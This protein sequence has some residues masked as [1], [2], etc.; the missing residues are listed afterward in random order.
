L[1]QQGYE[2]I[3]EQ[4]DGSRARVDVQRRKRKSDR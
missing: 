3:N 2:E 1:K 4:T